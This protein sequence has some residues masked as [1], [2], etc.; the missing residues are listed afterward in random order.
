MHRRTGNCCQRILLPG[1][2]LGLLAG[3]GGGGGGSGGDAPYVAVTRVVLRGEIT[4]NGSPMEVLVDGA[5]ANID[6]DT[7][8]FALDLSGDERVVTITMRVKGLVVAARQVS[9]TQ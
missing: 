5:P 6:G 9:V 3:C 8:S 4:A 2:L 1:M 7:W